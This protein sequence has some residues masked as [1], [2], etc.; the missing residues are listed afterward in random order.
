MIGTQQALE[1]LADVLKALFQFLRRLEAVDSNLQESARA[2][3]GG[4]V[5]DLA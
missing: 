2:V 3:E 5:K 4:M 1:G